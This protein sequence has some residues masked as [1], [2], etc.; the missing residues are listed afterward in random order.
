[1]S[2]KTNIPTGV[3]TGNIAADM[4]Y[5]AIQ[6]YKRHART[7]KEVR[8]S[9]SYWK[10][11]KYYVEKK[12]PELVLNDGAI[13]FNNLLVVKG[14]RFMRENAEFILNPKVNIDERQP[15]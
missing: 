9:H 8:L 7:I 12:K 14:T 4:I 5:A 2:D 1:M 6:H 10:I 3:N 13:Q 15:V 11:F